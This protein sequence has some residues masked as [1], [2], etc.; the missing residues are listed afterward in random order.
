MLESVKKQ[1]EAKNISFENIEN[2]LNSKDFIIKLKKENF[3]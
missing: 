3:I 1:I 2:Y